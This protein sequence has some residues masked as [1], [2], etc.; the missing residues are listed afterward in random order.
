[1]G[2]SC[3]MKNG[4][5]IIEWT[6]RDDKMDESQVNGSMYTVKM[7]SC[8]HLTSQMEQNINLKVILGPD[9]FLLRAL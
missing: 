4:V 2:L 1:M 5:M 7:D 6:T 8:C 3:I 9:H